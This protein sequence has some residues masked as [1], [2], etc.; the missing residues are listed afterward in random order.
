[1]LFISKNKEKNFLA[2]LKGS[3][4]FLIVSGLSSSLIYSDAG[5][6]GSVSSGPS[7]VILK[8]DSVS[9]EMSY[10]DVLII[11]SEDTGIYS[12]ELKCLFVFNDIETNSEVIMAFPLSIRTPFYPI[13][14]DFIEMDGS[15]DN[16]QKMDFSVTIDGLDAAP[17][18]VFCS[19][20]DN[21]IK[22]GMSWED[23]SAAIK[24]LNENEPEDGEIIYY[25][26]IFFPEDRSYPIM[27]PVS[28]LACWKVDFMKNRPRLVEFS[29]SY[30]LTSDY[31]DKVFRLSYPLFTGSSW[32]NSIGQGK[33]SVVFED[34]ESQ[35]ALKYYC[36]SL[37][38]LPE[39]YEK[40][41]FAEPLKGVYDNFFFR[42]SD[43]RSYF[44]KN[45]YGAIVWNFSDL[46][47]TPSNF[48]F[49]SYYLDIG[50][51][52]AE[53]YGMASDNGAESLSGVGIP[54]CI[55]YI[56]VV[57]GSY[58]PDGFYVI[59]HTGVDFFDNPQLSG[60]PIF[61]API[62]SFARLIEEGNNSSKFAVRFS[63]TE[64]NDTGYANIYLLDENKLLRP[65][66]VPYI[67]SYYD[68]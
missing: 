19:F 21:S 11:I 37:L 2:Q 10:E 65:L 55:S 22:N 51:V 25:K 20:Y 43:S 35:S 7:P 18:I 6:L 57:F 15:D 50:D 32:A 45:Y 16:G 42:T 40:E 46:E 58:R 56:Y 24:V 41:Y 39:V 62:F 17:E 53:L 30:T 59:D 14:Y 4:I 13:Y 60:D 34:V 29:Q 66:M 67:D 36:G 49:Q 5:Y 48:R 47:P 63:E 68:E 23:F 44:N 26:E 33:I 12:A 3:F 1:M 54:W 27:E 31:N 64:Y 52:G 61:K 8:E 38:P 28:V 9:V